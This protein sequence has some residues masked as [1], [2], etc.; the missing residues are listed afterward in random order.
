MVVFVPFAVIIL[1]G[2]GSKIAYDVVWPWILEHGRQALKYFWNVSPVLLEESRPEALAIALVDKE[3]K[4]LTLGGEE[5]AAQDA[6]DAETADTA[7]TFP[8]TDASSTFS[9]ASASRRASHAQDVYDLETQ[10]SLVY[11]GFDT[12]RA[13]IRL[14]YIARAPN[15]G[16]DL[17]CTYK[18]VHLQTCEAYT[19]LSYQWGSATTDLQTISLNGRPVEVTQNLYQALKEL[20]ARRITTVWV[21]QLCLNQRD[22]S[23]MALQVERMTLIYNRAES[24]FAWLGSDS[25]EFLELKHIFDEL[26]AFRNLIGFHG[27]ALT[28]QYTLHDLLHMWMRQPLG[29][30]GVMMTRGREKYFPKIDT[31]LKKMSPNLGK[32]DRELRAKQLHFLQMLSSIVAN[33]YWRRAWILQELT[34]ASRIQLS[35]GEHSLDFNLFS[36]II[37]ELQGL[38][39]DKIFPGFTRNYQ[40]IFN[41]IML[42]SK[43]QPRQPIHL[44]T[45]LQRSHETVATYEYD[46]IYSLLG[47]CFD[48][49]R[50]MTD[51]DTESSID[52]IV[53]RMTETSIQT[54]R[55]L[56]IICLQNATGT[57][58]H[59]LPSWAPNWLDFGGDR[60]NDRLIK[61][62]TGQDEHPKQDAGEQYW[63]ATNDS[64]HDP[65]DDDRDG[66]VLKVKG[67]R[68][69]SISFLSGAAT[70]I[71]VTRSAT[72]VKKRNKL[73]A[74]LRSTAKLLDPFERT[75]AGDI[76]EAL[77]IYKQKD[78]VDDEMTH[79]D[80]LW[81]GR[82]IDRLKEHAPTACK[83]LEQHKDFLLHGERL[84][85]WGEGSFGVILQFKSKVHR[86]LH[87]FVDGPNTSGSAT[88]AET[89]QSS[90]ESINARVDKLA[91][92]VSRVLKDGLRL[93][94][95]KLDLSKPKVEPESKIAKRFYENG[96]TG[97]A[98]PLAKPDD[99]IY[100]LKGCSMPVILRPDVE[101]HEE[102]GLTF[103]VVGD[104]YVVNAMHGEAWTDREE[105]LERICLV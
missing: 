9:A 61:Y 83:W 19:A 3:T 99:Q 51:I 47:V 96:F 76:F 30:F 54:T 74:A 85:A 60:F 105:D 56:D 72:E 22:P 4:L 42:R 46:K 52:V 91:D 94:G 31:Q 103:R 68:I 100:L 63:R 43:W 87:H 38:S 79:F 89:V 78:R 34:V 39:E 41:I 49:N 48:Y 17:Y 6:E 55:T 66:K 5:T 25:F 70:D 20:R 82:T 57:R 7:S 98:H 33:D 69:G 24:V 11:Q 27:K 1:G 26:T 62:F 75:Q 29:S 71:S 92:A 40:H 50:F 58:D 10:Q 64:R 90:V 84:S 53:R 35:C 65:Q 2:F 32:E 12:V 44:L 104:A 28:Q 93:M 77:T 13:Q 16:D 59:R 102:F 37:Q 81:K 23:E 73:V 101:R 36:K 86:F 14:L 67:R 88:M 80:D 18:P 45:A 8:P 15:R 21:D 95:G 97:W